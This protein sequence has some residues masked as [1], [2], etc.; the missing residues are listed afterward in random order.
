MEQGQNIILSAITSNPLQSDKVFMRIAHIDITEVF[1]FPDQPT[2]KSVFF[3]SGKKGRSW[4][5]FGRSLG[6]YCS[7]VGDF[8]FA[9]DSFAILSRDPSFRKSTQRP[10]KATD[11]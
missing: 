6:C 8:L 11:D 4:G 2:D 3:A 5:S 1:S 7:A 9:G 10:G